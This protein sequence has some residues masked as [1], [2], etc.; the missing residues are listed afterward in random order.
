MP[1]VRRVISKIEREG[2]LFGEI[3]LVVGRLKVA[4]VRQSWSMWIGKTCRLIA[5]T[6]LAPARWLG[7]ARGRINKCIG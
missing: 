2:Y 3:E 1:H 5:R 6:G 7:C 4:V